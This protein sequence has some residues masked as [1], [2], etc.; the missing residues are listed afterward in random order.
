MV[1]FSYRRS[2]C[3]P[4]V[5][6]ARLSVTPPLPAGRGFSSPAIAGARPGPGLLL[7]ILIKSFWRKS[8]HGSV[9][10]PQRDGALFGLGDRYLVLIGKFFIFDKKSEGRKLTACT[11]VSSASGREASYLVPAGK[12]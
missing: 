2:C 1:F 7:G 6:K 11:E 4:E 3:A 8:L 9:L 12:I 5:K 10:A